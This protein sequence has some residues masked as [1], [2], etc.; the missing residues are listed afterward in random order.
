MKINPS[1]TSYFQ[2][3]TLW[4][5]THVWHIWPR[6]KWARNTNN[7]SAPLNFIFLRNF[8]F[9]C[10]RGGRHFSVSRAVSQRSA[11][12]RREPIE[13]AESHLE[14]GACKHKRDVRSISTRR[15]TETGSWGFRVPTADG[16]TWEFCCHRPR[17]SVASTVS[18]YHS[19][20]VTGSRLF[21]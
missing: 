21:R 6:H 2:H 17:Q 18:H 11:T 13:A 9:C 8:V 19:T 5:Q 7:D 3:F 14:R 1:E 12:S 20:D 15:D 4:I 16:S 10:Q